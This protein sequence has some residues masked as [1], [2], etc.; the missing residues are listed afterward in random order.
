MKNRS[1]YRFLCILFLL[2]FVNLAMLLTGCSVKT[3]KKDVAVEDTSGERLSIGMSF[4][5]FVIERWI[6]DRD[7]F[8]STAEDLGAQVNVQNA[9]GN[10][11]E[12]IEQIEY[13]IEKKMDVIVI[14]AIDGDALGDVVKRAREA[15]IRVVC[16]DRLIRNAQ[17]DLYISFDNVK[18]GSLMGEA[19]KKALPD[20]GNIFAIYGSESDNNVDLVIEGLTSSLEGSGLNIVY[21]SYC[22]NWLAELAFTAVNEGLQE[23]GSVDGIMCGNDDLA[24]QAIRALSE[25]RLAGK[26]AVVAQDAELSACQRIVE[27]TQ[28]MTVYKSVEELARN[29]A[30]LAVALAKH[31]DITSEECSL[32]VTQKIDDGTAQIPY[33]SI[34][35]M[36]VTAEN[37]DD[38]IIGSGF[39]RREDVYLNVADTPEAAG[40]E[41]VE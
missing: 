38:V 24:S 34:D 30:V 36:S 12:Q 28:T 23:Y 9:N 41:A 35:P 31:E 18:V 4:D 32:Q 27:G 3:E 37:M 2:L 26:V 39:H 1:R 13:F 25:H 11:D 14:I 16:Y 29:A 6:R 20:G 15:G 19:L 33:F 40:T 22:R 17:T 21:S 8:I 5:S 7:V 10:V